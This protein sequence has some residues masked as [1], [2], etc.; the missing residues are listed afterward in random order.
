MFCNYYPL[1]QVACV[2]KTKGI[3]C[4][5]N[6]FENACVEIKSTDLG[7]IPNLN[8]QACLQQQRNIDGQEVK[9]F[10]RTRCIHANQFH[11][12]NL[13]CD[14]NFSIF[15]C[16]NLYRKNCI[17]TNNTCVSYQ[18]EIQKGQN[19]ETIFNSPVSPRLCAQIQDLQCKYEEQA[20][21]YNNGFQ[22]GYFCQSVSDQQLQQL[23]CNTLGLSKEACINIKTTGQKCIFIN[24]ICRNFQEQDEISCLSY[25][26]KEACFSI[27]NP[28]LLCVWNNKGCQNY[29]IQSEENC[30]MLKNVNSSVC[31]AMPIYC[32]YDEINHQCLS[33]ISNIKQNCNTKG[34]NQIGC[35]SIKN[36]KCIYIR[37]EGCQELRD[38]QL[39]KISCSDSINEDACINITTP[40]QYCQWN[41]QKCLRI[42]LNQDL[43]CPLPEENGKFYQVN[44]NVCQA[45]SKQN[46][47][48]KYN[49]NTKLCERSTGQETCTT[50]YL[51][52]S[53]CVQ[54]SQAMACI[55]KEELSKCEVVNIIDQ[56]TKCTDLK[57]S[58]PQACSQISEFTN[59]NKAVGCYFNSNTQQCD[60]INQNNLANMECLQQGLNKYGCTM[61][62]KIGQ[63][64]RWFRGQCTSIRS[65]EQIAQISCIELKFVNPGT[66]G[67][68]TFNKEVC[69]YSI[70]GYGCVNSI[71][72]S[73][74]GD[75]CNTLGLN[76]FAC[77]QITR[78]V[79]GCY[80]DKI[81]NV[82]ILAP[83]KKSSDESVL[84]ASKLLLT[85]AK[86]LASSPTQNICISIETLGEQCTW[87]YRTS[88]CEYQYVQFN[89]K[90]L[91]YNTGEKQKT[92]PGIRIS[93]NAN[94]CASILMNFP[95]KDPIV[96]TKIEDPLRGYCQY[97]G[98]GNCI[99][100]LQTPCITKC[101]TELVGINAHVCS[102]FTTGFYCYF[103]EFNKCVELTDQI[104]DINSFQAV[105]DYYNFKQYKC[106]SMNKNSCWM[107]DWSP[108]QQCYW[109]GL[110]CTQINFSDYPNFVLIDRRYGMNRYG[111]QGI[112]GDKNYIMKYYRYNSNNLC[113]D[114]PIELTICE[115]EGINSNVCLGFSSNLY[116]KWD[117]INL[118]CV[119]IDDYL[120]LYTCN[121]NQNEKACI[122][123]PYAPC[124]F[125][126]STDK[127]ITSP[128]DI[129]C[130]DFNAGQV[131]DGVVNEKACQNIT[132]GGQICSYNSILKKCES[133]TK[134]QQQS[135]DLP[136]INS[137]GCYSVTTANCRWDSINLNCYEEGDNVNKQLCLSIL[138]DN[139][140][141]S[142]TDMKCSQVEQLKFVKSETL[143]N[144]QAC[145]N[146]VG[147]AYYFSSTITNNIITTQC[148]KLTTFNNKCTQFAMNKQACLLNTREYKCIF[149]PTQ[150][151]EK[152]CQDF[153][154]EQL[155]CQS[156]LQINIE[157]CMNIPSQC[158]FEESSLSCKQTKIQTSDNCSTLIV[159]GMYYN[160]MS[161]S[162]ISKS[163]SDKSTDDTK[164]ICTKSPI[165]NNAQQCYFEKYCSWDE[166]T[167]GCQL[168]QIVKGSYSPSNG[169]NGPSCSLTAQEITCSNIYSMALCLEIG[170]GCYFNINQGGCNAYTSNLFKVTDCTQ[171]NGSDC[172]SSKTQNAYCKKVINENDLTSSCEQDPVNKDFCEN[173]PDVTTKQCLGITDTTD[174]SE[175]AQ[176]SDI[177]YFN[178]ACV[179]PT[180]YESITCTSPGVS[181]LLCLLLD[182]PCDFS[183]GSC[184][185][186]TIPTLNTD[187]QNYYYICNEVNLLI[188]NKSEY[189]CGNI[190]AAPCK[191]QLNS[192]QNAFFEQC[193]LLQDITVSVIACNQCNGSPTVYDYS[194]NKC[195]QVNDLSSNCDSLNQS[196]CELDLKS[197]YWDDKSKK[198]HINLYRLNR[199]SCQQLTLQILAIWN[200]N[201]NL[202]EIKTENEIQSVT[203]CSILSR[204]ACL[205]PSKSCW[206]N[207]ITLQCEYVTQI[208]AS[209]SQI[210]DFEGQIQHCLVSF[211]EACKWDTNCVT[212][213]I[214]SEGCNVMNRYGCLNINNQQKLSCGWSNNDKKCAAITINLGL[215]C[216]NYLPNTWLN[217]DQVNPYV[218]AQLTL[219]TCYLDSNSNKCTTVGTKDLYCSLHK[220]INKL[221]CLISTKDS[222]KFDSEFSQCIPTNTENQQCSDLQNTGSCCLNTLNQVACLSMPNAYCKFHL[223][224]CSSFYVLDK[225]TVG[226]ASAL[227][228]EKMQISPNICNYYNNN[229]VGAYFIYDPVRLQCVNIDK[230]SPSKYFALCRSISL[231]QKGCLEKTMEYCQYDNNSCK[232]MTLD[233]VKQQTQCSQAY[234]WKACISINAFCKF[235]GG[236]C[237]PIQQ[238]DTCSNLTNAIVGPQV[239]AQFP[240][241]CKYNTLT[242]SCIVVILKIEK[243]SSLGLSKSG[244]LSYTSSSFC[245]FD[246][247]T[248]K[249]TS[250]YDNSL[251]CTDTNIPKKWFVNETKCLY[252]KT[253]GNYCQFTPG[254]QGECTDIP[255]NLFTGACLLPSIQTNPMTC[256]RAINEVC[257]YNQITQR[258]AIGDVNI[259]PWNLGFSFNKL[260]CL[261]Y[262]NSLF[263]I[264]LIWDDVK[265]CIELT[266][267]DLANIQCNSPV[268]RLACVSITNPTQFCQFNIVTFKCESYDYIIP[269]KDS[270]ACALLSNVNRFEFCQ[271]ASD[272]CVYNSSSR[273]CVSV[274]PT[275]IN[276]SGDCFNIGMSKSMCEQFSSQCQF[277]DSRRFCYG[278]NI[279]CNNNSPS[280]CKDVKTE[281]CWI[282]NATC[283]GISFEDLNTI[284]CED[285]VNQLGCT[286]ITNPSKVCQYNIQTS[287]CNEVVSLTNTCA[288]YSNVNTNRACE[289]TI[290]T[291]CKFDF[292]AKSCKEVSIT[293]VFECDRGLNYKACITYTRPSL[294]CKFGKYCYGPTSGI[295]GCANSLNKEVCLNFIYQCTWDPINSLCTDYNLNG[296]TCQQLQDQKIVV[297]SQVCYNAQVSEGNACVFDVYTFTCKIIQPKSCF[298]LE[299][300]HQ[301]QQQNELPCL[302]LNG[303][304]QL[305][306]PISTDTCLNVGNLGSKNA[307]LSIFRK[308]QFCQYQ[309]FNC[310][311]YKENFEANNCLDNI[312]KIACISQ[313]TNSCIW[314]TTPKEIYINNSE[315]IQMLLGSCTK[316][317]S[318]NNY[319]CDNNL[320][321]LSCLSISKY[322]QH[323]RWIKG[324]C[325]S[326]EQITG[327]VINYNTYQLINQN[328][329]GLVNQDNVRYLDQ[330]KSCQLIKNNET[331]TCKCGKETKGLNK[332]ACLSI[333]N[334][335]CKWITSQSRCAEYLS[336][337]DIK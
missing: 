210:N 328:A 78:N 89:E 31:R 315:K 200:E 14:S 186:L 204:K 123:N 314:K 228:P 265:G 170:E 276:N 119:T 166:T 240:T 253:S 260:A 61:I 257:Y 246:A 180:S 86:C 43:D 202:C 174:G 54:I 245:I 22:N 104:V 308:G 169:Q 286:S 79:E 12:R 322:G 7:C 232:A 116:C 134:A 205:I 18:S 183:S 90:C 98:K 130:S 133:I 44:G 100:F 50:P 225:V 237:I 261:R 69:K 311:S 73:E 28:S 203:D 177:C 218:C 158:Y 106:S 34:L 333:K 127:C 45:I 263:Q 323:C 269:P 51:N 313:Q 41:G 165:Q 309:N 288:S 117:K 332:G 137:I 318:P 25:V 277:N 284:N 53:A 268:N 33:P 111:C 71:N 244:C 38:D 125:L 252:I 181:K 77:S 241:P 296:Q 217:Y 68:V 184:T 26:N 97:D 336:L 209:C 128:Q 334:E 39:N 172:T 271:Y 5:F 324:E 16:V 15:A 131:Y 24:N 194:T 163:L 201:K 259:I 330:T 70:D 219:G 285:V 247:L 325:Q 57:Y 317:E 221:A 48:C 327:I 139:C 72:S 199:Q 84:A 75:Y 187:K 312:N 173:D 124:A 294:Q 281:P 192:C 155:V 208:M 215:G 231:S 178:T 88:G 66:C 282:V 222:C 295:T 29:L 290:D 238:T 272:S 175:C 149:D 126:K 10:F 331:I 122:A 249:C 242:Y 147:D 275:N 300:Q 195:N 83:D 148:Q 112:E 326:I 266:L 191:Y 239:C 229:I 267:N 102:R 135:C 289:Q 96:T 60:V 114:Y 19:C 64:C 109:D 62:T 58:N 280:T 21:G 255:S 120:S 214:A 198:C 161:C 95:N 65:K 234:N 188:T 46:I 94:V 171:I 299:S 121:E 138:N 76:S 185:P 278:G 213:N 80:F 337:C 306:Q 212:A 92:I 297:S 55:W 115:T 223:D 110:V 82:C 37:E 93:V 132:K 307:C 162:S 40:F 67:L 103:N 303:A 167:Y 304:C 168:H 144:A 11:L 262:N 197:C 248:F 220:G 8:Q 142:I 30:E 320:S 258:C 211:K 179:V 140:E 182:P 23:T 298:E 226:L 35:L 52:L 189:A 56:V 206:I 305:F 193:S 287:T 190:I 157:I 293:D 316:F 264:K 156:L 47:G 301:C 164:R 153:K 59:N 251:P 91:D 319:D 36:Q 274:L 32:F 1:D 129:N 321:Y 230:P 279:F 151:P 270:K 235:Q 236:Q 145:T 9:C 105:K 256:T 302:W 292:L 118:Q 136:G 113:V 227:L 3:S 146:L 20:I 283:Q 310:I 108:T 254:D 216:I 250:T 101:C 159:E 141:W 154:Q 63:R 99:K 2:Q 243:C 4:Q 233:F 143:Y 160:K 207:S 42:P 224:V 74:T 152:K 27:S 335:N 49:Q 17:W 291:A 273:N 87:N 13:D 196:N 329:C 6:Y 81:N 150:I 107:I 176:A 85:T